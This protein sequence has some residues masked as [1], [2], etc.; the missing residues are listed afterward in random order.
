M[1][2]QRTLKFILENRRLFIVLFHVCLVVVAFYAAFLLR[3]DFNM[4]PQYWVAFID[5]LAIL[6]PVKLAVFYFFGLYTGGML[7]L[8]ETL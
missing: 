7:K 1:M 4:P 5:R 8:V 6:L 3:F 2:K